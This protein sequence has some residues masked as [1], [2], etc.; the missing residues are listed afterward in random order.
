[1]ATRTQKEWLAAAMV[2][3]FGTGALAGCGS[4]GDAPVI[5]PGDGGEYAPVIDPA[6]FVEEINNPYLPLTPGSRWVYLGEEDGESERVEVEVTDARR[7]VMEVSTVVVRDRVFQDGELVEDTSDWFAQDAEGNVWYF[8]EDS[9]ELE[10]GEVVS[11]EGSWE[12]GVD[13]ALPGVVML[14]DPAVG[15]RRINVDSID[16]RL[17]QMKE[18]RLSGTVSDAG[19]F[20]NV[21]IGQVTF[22]APGPSKELIFSIVLLTA[23]VWKWV[24]N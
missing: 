23:E 24:D 21:T 9:K 20:G 12:A 3:A 5:D 19:F 10:D 22:G 18:R 14:A 1:M 13:G 16:R 17:S 4:G 6:S 2:L 8:G 15:I 11:T 7:E